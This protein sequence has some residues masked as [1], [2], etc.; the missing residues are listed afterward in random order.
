MLDNRT[1][2]FLMVCQEMNF[3]RAAD[4]LHITQPAVTQHIQYLEKY[5]GS[6]LFL[7]DGKKLYLTEAGKLLKTALSSIYNNEIYLK[8]QIQQLAGPKRVLRFGATLTVGEFLIAAPLSRFLH[9]HPE[10]EVTVTV[11]NTREL[12]SKL[13]AG[14]I[15]FAVLEGDFSKSTYEH[16]PYLNDAFIPIC[17]KDDFQAAEAGQLTDL[18]DHR[19]IIREE[20]SGTR[21]ILEQALEECGLTLRGFSSVATIGNMSAIKELVASGCGITFLYE[22]AVQRELTQGILRKIN[23]CDFSI[24]HQI[25]IVWNKGNFFDSAFRQLFQELFF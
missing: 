6:K 8:E 16:Q 14:Q 21:K 4:K 13:D 20:G 11:A 1:Q 2:T 22:T 7:L 3:T 19:L 15:D 12:L 24:R 23:L 5:Y 25:S 17:G 9:T 10:T 18:F